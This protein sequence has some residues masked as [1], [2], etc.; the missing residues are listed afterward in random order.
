MNE[1]L[2]E[3]R[4]IVTEVPGTTRDTIEENLDIEGIT[5]KITDTAGIRS[6][7]DKIEKIGIEKTKEAFNNADLVLFMLDAQSGIDR[8]DLEIVEKIGEKKC[9]IIINKID[10]GKNITE[11]Q[12]RELFKSNQI[13]ETSLT[14]NIGLN[15][16]KKKITEMVFSGDLKQ[17]GNIVITNVRHKNLL[18]KASMEIAEA[19]KMMENGEALDFVHVNINQVFEY[20]GEITGQTIT[21]DIMDKVFSEFCI[22]K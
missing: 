10:L 16:I 4:A 14:K 6:T 7:E 18:K 12:I 17:N 22:G 8:S 11:T 13:I 5:V 20:L 3:S 19:V 2:R 21:D 9:L 15:E 1:L